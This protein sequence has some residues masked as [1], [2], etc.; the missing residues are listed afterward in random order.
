V[1]LV[2]EAV[3]ATATATRPMSANAGASRSDCVLPRPT[4]GAG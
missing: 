4:G 2:A 1:N 3:A